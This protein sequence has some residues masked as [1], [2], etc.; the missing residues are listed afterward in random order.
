M[1]L[2]ACS[3][4]MKKVKLNSRTS[5]QQHLNNEKRFAATLSFSI[6]FLPSLIYY[7]YNKILF[8]NYQ[9]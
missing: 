6:V 8:H 1:K 5:Q 4:D 9:G 3:K 2:N 7:P